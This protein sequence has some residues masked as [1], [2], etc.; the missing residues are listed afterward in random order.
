MIPPKGAFALGGGGIGGGRATPKPLK[1]KAPRVVRPKPIDPNQQANANAM[2]AFRT[3][4]AQLNQSTPP[5]DSAAIYAPYR[6]SEQV[7]GQ[8]GQGYQQAVLNSGAQAQSQYGDALKQAQGQAAAFGISAGAGANPTALQNTGAAPLAQQTNAYA[9]AAPAAAAQWQALLERT[10]GAKVAD[11]QAARDQ[12]LVSAR[13]SLAGALPGAIQNEEQLGFQKQTQRD[14]IGLARTQLTA[15]QRADLQ[16]YTLGAAK[17]QTSA[18]N[19]AESAAIKR[20]SLAEKT[21]TDAAKLKQGARKLAQGD[22]ALAIK[23]RATQATAKGLKGI[24]AAAKALSGG[25]SSASS[26]TVSGYYVSITPGP[27][28][29]DA[30]APARKLFAKDPSNVK[31]PSGWQRSGDPQP[32]KGPTTTTKT[33]TNITPA[34]WD[35]QMRALLAQNPGRAGEIKAFLGPRPKGAKKK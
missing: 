9:A 5:V 10:A 6:A 3:A 13:Q 23:R 32:V 33:T 19:A 2:S 16:D 25:V 11:A 27:N 15:K 8:L 24:P 26:N 30:G 20:A 21:S 14:N 31:I 1:P 29:V 28:S 18:S 34:Q 35:T 4:L 12:G 7:T 17:V 22:Q